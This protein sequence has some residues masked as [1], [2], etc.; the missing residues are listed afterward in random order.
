V[1]AKLDAGLARNSQRLVQAGRSGEQFA[2]LQELRLPGR[3]WAY[4]GNS[5]AA[6]VARA[7]GL[8]LWPG[9]PTREGTI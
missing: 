4:T 3:Y 9:E 1:E 7:L 8:N 2:L 5:T 6:G